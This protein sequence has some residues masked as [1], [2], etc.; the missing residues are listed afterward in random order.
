M[1]D[2]KKLSETLAIGFDRANFLT[3]RI[4]SLPH[5]RH[6]LIPRYTKLKASKE[7]F[8]LFLA[9]LKHLFFLN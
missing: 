8:H 5:D 3:M 6:D 2:V 7:Y 4:T 1:K 9:V